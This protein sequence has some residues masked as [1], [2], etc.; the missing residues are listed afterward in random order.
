MAE[1]SKEHLAELDAQVDAYIK[2]CDQMGTRKS[3]AEVVF[4]TSRRPLIGLVKDDVMGG[5]GALATIFPA[6][7]SIGRQA[8]RM[9]KDLFEGKKVGDLTPEWPA[10]YGVAV[11]LGKARRFGVDISVELLQLAAENIVP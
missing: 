10:K 8:G 9:I 1:K 6:H 5:W 11:D 3:F 7:D 2:P 4:Q